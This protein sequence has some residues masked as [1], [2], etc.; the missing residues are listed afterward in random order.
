MEECPVPELFEL[1]VVVSPPVSL[2][3]VED[4]DKGGGLGSSTDKT[5][6]AVFAAL[7]AAASVESCERFLRQSPLAYKPS[8]GLLVGNE[9]GR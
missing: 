5:T 3:C 1:M 4:E 7:T 2:V 8:K 9:D 6:D